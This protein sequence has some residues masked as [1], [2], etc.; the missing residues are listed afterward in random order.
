MAKHYMKNRFTIDVLS[1]IPFDNIL[2]GITKKKTTF[3]S[4]FSMLKLIRISRISRMIV[5]MN[6]PLETKLWMKL[7]YL[8]LSLLIYLHVTGCVWWF[9]ALKDEVWVPPLY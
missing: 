8:I 9:I 4:A 1:T 5:R 3:F 2:Y 6:S 7:F